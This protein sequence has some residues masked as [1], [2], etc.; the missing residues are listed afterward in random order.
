MEKKALRL[1]R[2]KATNK[3]I[4]LLKEKEGISYTVDE[5]KDL[6]FKNAL[7]LCDGTLKD[8]EVK[9]RTNAEAKY[10]VC[11]DVKECELLPFHSIYGARFLPTN[12]QLVQYLVDQK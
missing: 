9:T 12:K 7:T 5:L 3:L 4:S 2:F 10:L 6:F 1:S 8:R 11:N